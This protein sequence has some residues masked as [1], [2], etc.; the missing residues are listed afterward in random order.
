M[1]YYCAPK[2]R[3]GGERNPVR[4]RQYFQSFSFS[5]LF[6]DKLLLDLNVDVLFA[7]WLDRLIN[8]CG[9]DV[10]ASDF[11]RVQI[12]LPPS[13]YTLSNPIMHTGI[14]FGV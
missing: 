11:L 12:N 10:D 9:W 2:K 1:C 4:E 6:W 8:G 13:V 14:K 3:G 7:S 5:V